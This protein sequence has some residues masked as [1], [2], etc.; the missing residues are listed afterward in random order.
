[1]DY[2]KQL[3]I[4]CPLIFLSGFVDAIAGGG[5]LISLPAYYAVGLAPH[6]V[7]GTNKLS[8]F[9]GSSASAA[10]FIKNK[11]FYKET[12]IPSI[13]LAL[14]GSSFGAR[15]AMYLPEEVLRYILIIALP[16]L[17]IF[18][19]RNKGFAEPDANKLANKK[20]VLIICSAA[21]FIVG[22]YDGFF[23]PGTGTFLILIYTSF[24]GFDLLTSMGNAKIVNLSANIAA[25]AV[26]AS[27]GK[28][29]YAL[30]IPAAASSMLGHYLG[31]GLAL[32]NGKKI[33]KPMMLAVM[34]LLLIKLISDSL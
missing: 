19:L 21:S 31:S 11:S 15:L 5:A 14:L 4:L 32:K 23:G 7:L 26:F 29:D 6:T 17:A 34:A 9:V 16:L 2:F 10:R 24:V 25:L 18:I 33:V 12:V 30:A 8:S 13:A 1:M 22:A 20:R 3:L 28:V 27:S